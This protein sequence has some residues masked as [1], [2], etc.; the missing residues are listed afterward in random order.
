MCF[1]QS[2]DVEDEEGFRAMN[3]MTRTELNTMIY[4]S[5]MNELA[6]RAREMRMSDVE[7]NS[8]SMTKEVDGNW[9]TEHWRCAPLAGPKRTDRGKESVFLPLLLSCRKM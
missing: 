4:E 8:V 1:A 3:E 6:M 7:M 2:A 5:R 9:G